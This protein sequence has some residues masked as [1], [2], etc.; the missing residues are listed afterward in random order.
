MN[1]LLEHPIV[2]K[3][4]PP[5]GSRQKLREWGYVERPIFVLVEWQPPLGGTLEEFVIRGRTMHIPGKGSDV[6]LKHGYVINV[7]YNSTDS[8]ARH[9]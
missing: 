2:I 3:S 1:L 4:M 7:H 9:R 8:R 5:D 6:L